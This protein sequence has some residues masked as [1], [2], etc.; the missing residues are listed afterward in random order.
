[1]ILNKKY[2]DDTKSLKT[3]FLDAFKLFEAVTAQANTSQI[4]NLCDIIS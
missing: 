1:M 2:N 3:L 4:A